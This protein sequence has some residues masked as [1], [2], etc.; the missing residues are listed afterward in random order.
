MLLIGAGETIELVARHLKEQA[1]RHM[2]VANR[3]RR[4]RAG[5]GRRVRRRGD[6]ARRDPHAPGRRRHRHLLDRQP[7]PILGKGAV[8][9]ALKA[10][11]HRP[12]F[13]VDIA[14]PRD[15]EPEVGELGDVY[16]YTVDDLKEV[17]QEN[18]ESRREAAREA[19]GIIDTQVVRLHALGAL[20]RRRADHPRPA[21]GGRA[22]ARTASSKRAR[23]RLASAATI[24]KKVLEQLARALTNKFTHAPS[25]CAHQ[26]R[27]RRR[28]REL[29]DAARRLFNLKEV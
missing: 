19:E 27:A 24:R 26:R 18:L 2:I 6:L 8:E 25:R 4:A 16:L 28:T 9:S 15:I 11:R 21:R 14:V 10:R 29:L 3:T 7:L 22:A 20:A 5:P 23:A 1:V 17:V 13:M 12:M